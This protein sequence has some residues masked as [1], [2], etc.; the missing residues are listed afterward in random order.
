[1]ARMHRLTFGMRISFKCS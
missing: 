1:M